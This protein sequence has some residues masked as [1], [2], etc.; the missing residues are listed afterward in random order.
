MDEETWNCPKKE[1]GRTRSGADHDHRSK[2]PISDVWSTT[3]FGAV[4]P[5]LS[6]ALKEEKGRFRPGTNPFDF[7]RTACP[8]GLPGL[9]SVARDA[10]CAA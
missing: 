2:I 9:L 4:K 10:A 1:E 7:S 3:I 8:G 5:S 6:V